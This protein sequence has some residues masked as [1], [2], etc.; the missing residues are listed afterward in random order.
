M[1]K[2]WGKFIGL[3]KGGAENGGLLNVISE[4]TGK[5]SFRRI[6]AIMILAK[7]LPAMDFND[8]SVEQ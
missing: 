3:G 1:F 6:A 8:S 2:N 4:K 7:M 5:I